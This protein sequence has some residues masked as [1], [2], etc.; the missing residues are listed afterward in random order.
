MIVLIFC[1]KNNQDELRL[2]QLLINFIKSKY[3][4]EIMSRKTGNDEINIDFITE[5]KFKKI[6]DVE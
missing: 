4:Y 3:L 1:S 5:Q 2:Y 6:C